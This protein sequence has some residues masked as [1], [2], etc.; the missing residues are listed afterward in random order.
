MRTKRKCKEVKEYTLSSFICIEFSIQFRLSNRLSLWAGSIITEEQ[1]KD[2]K[3]ESERKRV[4]NTINSSRTGGS[5]LINAKFGWKWEALH[6]TFQTTTPSIMIFE[7]K[8]L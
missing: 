6:M 3:R 8:D 1:H 4:I 5:K 7:I 2:R